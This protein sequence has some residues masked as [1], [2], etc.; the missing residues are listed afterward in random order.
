MGYNQDPLLSG[1]IKTDKDG[2]YTFSFPVSQ[3]RSKGNFLTATVSYKKE[4]SNIKLIIPFDAQ[5]LN[6][7]FY[8]EGGNLVHA[9]QSLIGWE[10]KSAY[11]APVAASGILYKDKIPIDTIYTDHY[12]LGKFKLVPLVGSTY[13]VK[14]VGAVNDTSYQLPN[15]LIK[16]PVI[17]LKN[18]IADDSLQIHITSKYSAKYL[19][20]VHNYRQTFFSFPVDVS[21]AGK[22]ALIILKG[23]PKGLTTITIL[24]SLQRQLC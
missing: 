20:L 24:D 10:V 9:T 18:A 3:I 11:G 5:K 8:P 1:K 6:V 14:I 21:G 16:G 7:K 17:S 4:S 23:I 15:I 22:T 19:V 12:G 13:K 2:R